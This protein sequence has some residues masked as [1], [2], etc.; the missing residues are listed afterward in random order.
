MNNQEILQYLKFQEKKVEGQLEALRMAISTIEGAFT[1]ASSTVEEVVEAKVE[2]PVVA[3]ET[4]KKTPAATK[5]T[6]AAAPVA[7]KTPKAKFEGPSVVNWEVRPSNDKKG[8]G[9]RPVKLGKTYKT[10]KSYTKKIAFLLLKEGDRSSQE[11][12]DRI[13]ELEPSESNVKV[14]RS[15]AIGTSSMYRK[16][17]INARKDGRRYIYSLQAK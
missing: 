2:T 1:A 6:V 11:L 12:M 7:E 17:L 8:K 13:K 3:L 4:V 5:K 9:T 14:E 10:N 15:V 16:G